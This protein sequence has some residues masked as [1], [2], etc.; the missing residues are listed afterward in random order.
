M[1]LYNVRNKIITLFEEQNI[2]PSDYPHNSKSEPEEFDK[3]EPELEES[4]A[5]KTKMRRQKKSGKEKVQQYISLTKI[6]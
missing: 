1:K 5:E 6:L 3:F 2:K 4:I